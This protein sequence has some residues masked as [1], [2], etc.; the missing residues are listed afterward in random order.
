MF[1]L[2]EFSFPLHS[3][4]SGLTVK[5]HRLPFHASYSLRQIEVWSLFSSHSSLFLIPNF[6]AR[7]QILFHIR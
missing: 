6:H 2:F 7:V 5:I 3:E 4:N 1:I